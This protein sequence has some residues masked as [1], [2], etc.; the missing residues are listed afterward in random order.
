VAAV[1]GAGTAIWQSQ[2]AAQQR[3]LLASKVAGETA[4]R[5][6][7][8]DPGLALQ[9]ALAARRVADTPEARTSLHNAAF[10][11]YDTRLD[12][13][14]AM[15]IGL[16]YHP[17][18]RLL[19]SAARDHTVRLW[20]LSEPSRPRTTAV[21][22]TPVDSDVVLSPD[23][24]LLVAGHTGIAQQ[25]WNVADPDKPVAVASLGI[26]PSHVAFSANGRTLFALNKDTLTLWDL[27]D[28]GHPVESGTLPVGLAHV[29]SVTLSADDHTLAAAIDPGNGKFAVR[30]WNVTDPR[31]PV[32]AATLADTHAL[33][34]DFSPRSPILAVGSVGR[35]VHLWDTTDPTR[36]TQPRART[37]GSTS[38]S[39]T[40][41]TSWGSVAALEF[42]PDGHTLA[43]GVSS[44]TG[45]HVELIDVSD[46]AAPTTTA[47]YPTLSDPAASKK[48]AEYPTP[49]LI[50]ELVFGDDPAT[51][52]SIGEENFIRLWRPALN[53]L[54]PVH[55]IVNVDEI[56]DTDSRI[57]V[58]PRDA[59][60]GEFTL[61]RTD[62]PRDP[63][64]V[65]VLRTGT[66]Y[67]VVRAV[68]DRLLVE[69]SKEAPVR[70]WD[71][72]D[73]AHPVPRASLG[74]VGR[75]KPPGVRSVDNDLTISGHTIAV[76]TDD[77]QIHLWDIAD[78]RAP[79]PLSTVPQSD[80]AGD[81]IFLIQDGR[82]LADIN[83]GDNGD[84]LFW[85]VTDP[86]RPT[87]PTSV[88]TD[89]A[90]ARGFNSRLAAIGSGVNLQPVRLWDIS[91]PAH[92]AAGALPPSNVHGLAMSPDEH[93]L[94][95]ATDNSIDLWNIK[96]VRN[97]V[98]TG[99]I[100]VTT[101][102]NL[103]FSPDSRLLV[104]KS[105]KTRSRSGP[106]V[107]ESQLHLWDVTD[108]ARVTEV[109]TPTV[110]VDLQSAGFSPDGSTLYIASSREVRL[111]DPNI[112]S[113]TRQLCDAAG[114]PLS[115]SQW[116][117]Y[118]HGTPY[119]PPC[120]R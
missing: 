118:F 107:S 109:A 98:R 81:G 24:R 79:V 31:R 95:V 27:T 100:T 8:T 108:P 51:V 72:T 117:Q 28:P 111:L 67:P 19:V 48:T 45:N 47:E 82:T 23:G 113:L 116:R 32:T 92:P 69:F 60:H 58:L 57:L 90:L 68:D 80:V 9:L 7:D 75:K 40:S 115:P 18:R 33:D 76:N 70:L 91:D 4:D 3:D 41:V 38:G 59:Y 50:N 119:D 39:A 61:W 15:V 26:G 120:R 12:G 63:Q 16:A 62:G 64:Q 37:A 94:A 96:D 85:D 42:N 88:G 93:T 30:L 53:P 104:A 83:G 49:T 99:G 78:P 44:Q 71:I 14:T 13:H 22:P 52:F 11:P 10:A 84:T 54:L 89:I 112:D 2:V 73:P 77:G 110:P 43:A 1:A 20:D 55:G 17:G 5:I 102:N 106:A 74:R 46:P 66:E 101:P 87:K 97:P 114:G 25:L 6:R 103:D 65:G 29:M 56:T 36:P 21:L 34:V 86:R 105:G 35:G